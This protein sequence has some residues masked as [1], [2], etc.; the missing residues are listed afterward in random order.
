MSISFDHHAV[1]TAADSVRI[2]RL[3]PGP[4]E[5]VWDYLVDSD[6]RRL[7]L[8][9]GEM[10]LEAGAPVELVFR[11]E[12]LSEPPATPPARPADMRGGHR[13]AGR[14]TLCEPPHLLGYTWA[15]NHGDPSEVRFDLERRGDDVL[16][17]VTHT[18]LP[19]N[20]ALHSVAGGWHAHL[21]LLG[22][23]LRDEPV[24][25]FRAACETMHRAYAARM[26]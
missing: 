19:G 8:A 20:D 3:L 14:I 26:P 9:A 11:H 13:N 25:D 6:K 4:I 15:E 12:E 7:W 23:R 21:D 17:T 2:Q 5:R 10:V 22:R 1:R 16:L 24:G 18:R